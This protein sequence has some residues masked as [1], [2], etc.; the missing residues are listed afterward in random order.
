MNDNAISKA[1]AHTHFTIA[2][3]IAFC[4]IVI[5]VLYLTL[6]SGIHVGKLKLGRL[7]AE[8]LYLKWDKALRVEIGTL[9]LAPSD[10]LEEPLDPTALQRTV[11]LLLGHADDSW[12]GTLQIDRIRIGSDINGSLFYTPRSDS[13]FKIDA[14]GQ[15]RFS[16]TLLPVDNARAFRVQMQGD[17]T[18][19]R[20]AFRAEGVLQADEGELYLNGNI[21]VAKDIHLAVG[22][23]ASKT[24]LTV[25]ASSTEPFASVAPIV[26]PM[27]LSKNIESWIVARAEG[28]PLM[29]HT[30]RTTLPYADPAKAFDNL[31]GRLTFQNVRYRFANDPQAFDPAVAD[32]VTVTFAHK[33]LD[34]RPDHATFYGEPGG[35]VRVAIDF[36]PSDP[37]LL[38]SIA[39]SARFAP[40]LQRLTASYGIHLP[41]VQTEG[42]T[43]ANL[44]LTVDLGT[45]HTEATGRFRTAKSRIDL[46]GLP[47]AVAQADV[48]VKGA[49]VTIRSLQASLFDGNVSGSISGAFNPA[50]NHGSLRFDLGR[51]RYPIG[52]TP[53]ALAPKST[54]LHFEYR[55]D[56]RGDKIRF[57]ASRWRYKEHNLSAAAFTAPFDFKDLVLTL[58]KT[59][60]AYDQTAR[61]NVEGKISLSAPSATLLLDLVSLNAG[62]VKNVQDHTLFR[63]QADKNL[64]IS[65][66]AVTRWEKDG[67]PVSVSPVTVTCKA[68]TFRLSPAVVTIEKQLTGT[69]EGVFEPAT[70]STELNVSRF[71][72]ENERLGALFRSQKQFS[73][74]IVPI[75]DEYDIVIPSLNML[76]STQ[77][78][79]WLLH[80]FSL[81]A[82]TKESPLLR[83]YN[84]TQSDISVWTENGD[85]PI[86]FKGSINYPYALTSVGGKPVSVYSFRGNIEND[87]RLQCDINDRIHVRSDGTIHISSNGV[88]YSQPE[89]TRFYRDHQFASDTNASNASESNTSTAHIPVA[90]DA[91]NTAITFAGGRLAKADRITIDYERDHI[92]GH[93]YKAKGG[94]KLEVKGD[95]FYLFGYK[96]D[97]DFMSHFFN[98]ST[99]KGGTL[100]FYIIGEK[101]DFKGLIKINDTTVRDYVLFNNLFAFINTVPALVTFSLP[102]YA[103]DGIKVNS[104]YAELAFHEGKMTISGIK[105]DSKELDFAG[106]GVLNYNT[107]RIDLKLTVKTRAAENIRKIPLVGYILA[108]DDQSVLTTLKI[109]GPLKDPK[110]ENTIAKDIIITPFNILKRTLDFPVYYLKKLDS[111]D[112]NTS[113][114]ENGTSPITS[115]IPKVN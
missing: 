8:Q 69:V 51:V 95:K 91:N 60:V 108:G 46:S 104:A 33:V 36:G 32:T 94:A 55:F 24:A 107:D 52:S 100:D 83:D 35:D 81:G 12:I 92:T 61:A 86:R 3:V 85:Y 106:Q 44:S 27:H 98:L 82:F 75:D 79:G 29:L 37:L 22:M 54:P 74:Y 21:D 7:Y 87:G 76:Y 50:K 49:D 73:V 31:Y 101:D 96:L 4:L 11:A 62:G 19:F 56:P 63:I 109:T 15:G 57:D 53:I 68:R 42:S 38:F 23:H 5:G 105:V 9:F 1:I 78:Q 39:T 99:F 48:D 102:S 65:S 71:S 59:A 47:A 10:A 40:P 103:T 110:V 114:R 64:T 88:A 93:L 80:F 16:C 66:S 45:N 115:G 6:S 113:G 72:L 84:L 90:I 2:S 34:I 13:R 30:L 28:G 97:D 77:G 43:D 25:N 112:S 41:F 20:A 26:K 18:A 14:A 67:T 70:M 17:V 89:L 111:G 58:P